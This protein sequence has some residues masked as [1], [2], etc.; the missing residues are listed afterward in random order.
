MKKIG[1]AIL[2]AQ[3]SADIPVR[4]SAYTPHTTVPI[5]T[6]APEDSN[7]RSPAEAMLVSGHIN[8]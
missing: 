5:P 4:R 1:R 3:R 6:K 7:P 8:T 2:P